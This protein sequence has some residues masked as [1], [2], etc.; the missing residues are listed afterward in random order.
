MPR[1]LGDSF[2]HVDRIAALVPVDAP[3]PER[4]PEPL[5][6]GR[7]AR[8]AGN[9]ATLIPDGATLQ[10]GHRHDPRRGA[11]RARRTTTTSASTPRCSPT[12]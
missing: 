10:I 3:L 7:A 4:A 9:V 5:D 1:T 11:R 2:L 6:D 8:S 12:A